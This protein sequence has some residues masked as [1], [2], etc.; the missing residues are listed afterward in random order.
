MSDMGEMFRDWDEIK[1][2]EKESRRINYQELLIANEIPFVIKN[3]GAHLILTIQGERV[4]FWPGTN[5]AKHNDRYFY[6]ALNWILK[7]NKC[8]EFYR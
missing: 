5:R 2:Q 4:D 8:E 3:G 1:K 6:G 7:R